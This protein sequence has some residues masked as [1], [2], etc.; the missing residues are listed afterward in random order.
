LSGT[1]IPEGPPL[2]QGAGKPEI[3]GQNPQKTAGRN[4]LV[5][6]KNPPAAP[7][8]IFP[9]KTP[10]G[11]QVTQSSPPNTPLSALFPQN[12]L[13]EKTLE[14]SLDQAAYAREVFK[15]TAA[16]LRLPQ[17]NLS[18]ALLVFARYFSLPIKPVLI[19]QLRREILNLG[20]ASSPETAEENIALEAEAMA[21]VIAADKGVALG[22]ETLERYARFLLLPGFSPFCDKKEDQEDREPPEPED[23]RIMAQEQEEAN[24]FLGFLNSIPSKNG[25]YWMVF[26]L[27]ITV[28]G[29]EFNVFIRILKK[30]FLSSVGGEEVIV[31]ISGPKR[32][33]RCFLNK[34]GAKIRAD[35]RVFPESSPRGL[36]LLQKEAER[37]LGNF[38]SFEE[39]QVQN[40]GKIPSWVEDLSTFHLPAISKN[41]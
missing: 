30:E 8:S 36:K 18:V 17:D 41:V 5:E 2:K 15:Q 6:V 1:R 11:G 24:D 10:L 22:P 4:V 34:K 23:L 39:I 35:I 16:S 14:T 26:P 9:Q 32:Q 37:F 12:Q 40:G 13:L 7:G 21:A 25:Q 28:K 20:R 29:T 19:S 27:N 33:W 3:E 31:D 38:E